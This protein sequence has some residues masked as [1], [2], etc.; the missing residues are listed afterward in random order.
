MNMI[1]LDG[2]KDI[3]IPIDI[4]EPKEYMKLANAVAIIDKGSLK[5]FLF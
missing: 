2:L 1:S 5:T 3:E 4:H